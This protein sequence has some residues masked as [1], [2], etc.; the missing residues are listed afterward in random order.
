MKKASI[1]VAAVSIILAV[2]LF[3][4]SLRNQ[5]IGKLDSF[6]VCLKDKGTV[7]YGAFWCSHCKR[8]KSLFGTSEKFLP[9]V[10]CSTPDGKDQTQVCKDKQIQSYPT[11]LFA[12][13]SSASGELSLKD[14]SDRTGC[15]LPK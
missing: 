5:S 11:W 15:E 12:N 4:F 7:F 3:F 6:A 9:Y 2:I 13:E 10:E 8:Q 1:L 14:L